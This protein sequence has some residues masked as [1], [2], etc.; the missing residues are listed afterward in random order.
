MVDT[1]PQA[2]EAL[3]Q[4]LL[5]VAPDPIIIVDSRG[6]IRI[7]NRQ[8]ELAFGYSRDELVGERIEVLVPESLRERHIAH[9]E[10]YQADPHARPMGVG[11]ELFGRRKDRTLLAG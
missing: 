2:A 7:V 10:H 5:E 1:P 4:G 6:V 3:F 9:R 11:L 8:T